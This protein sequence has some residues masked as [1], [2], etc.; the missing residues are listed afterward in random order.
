MLSIK[1]K[2]LYYSITMS[3]LF[4]INCG[5]VDFNGG[6]VKLIYKKDKIKFLTAYDLIPNG[7]SVNFIRHFNCLKLSSAILLGEDIDD[8]KYYVC[9]IIS[10]INPI[11]FSVL[12]EIN[13]YV[14]Y[15]N[16]SIILGENSNSG[17]VAEIIL[18]TNLI[19]IISIIIKKLSKKIFGGNNV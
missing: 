10:C 2:K 15:K 3:N 13:P 11:I 6:S 4:K 16:D 7:D 17:F 12:N 8:Y 1:D 14:K 18:S 5:Y 9:S 19:S